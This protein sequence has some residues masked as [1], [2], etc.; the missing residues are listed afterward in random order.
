MMGPLVTTAW[1]AD[2]L[3]KPD[4]RVFDVTK[5]LPGIDRDPLAEFR[6]AH[7]P[8]AG[9]FD[10]DAIADTESDL[11]HML[12]A[13]GRFER[14]AGALGIS[15][16]TRVVFYDN[17][18]MMWAARGWWMLGVFGHDR[19]AVLDGGLPKWRGEG[20]ATETGEPASA[21]PAAFRADYRARRVRGIG[22]M[23]AN[24]TTRDELPVDARG[25]ARF[26]GEAPEPRAGMRGGHIPG[27]ANVHYADLLTEARTLRTPEEL[28]ARFAQAGVDGGRPV[29]TTC[30]SG[31][32]AALLTLGM[33]V[34]GL[35]IGAL[36]DGSWSEWGARADTPVATHE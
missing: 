5:F 33:A 25:A 11:S 3:G 6:A 8:G 28:R 31:V 1:L 21:T 32:S 26:R 27:S 2:E 15:N 34:A 24:V 29:V 30:G 13:P 22:D 20:R 19:A 18:D 14:M 23:L 4:L 9:Y 17:N 36:Y 35:P 12:P 16:A 10:I 7:I